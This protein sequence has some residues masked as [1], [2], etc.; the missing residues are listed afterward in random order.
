MYLQ[1]II[2]LPPNNNYKYIVS[3]PPNHYVLTRNN[4]VASQ[5][6]LL[7]VFNFAASSVYFSSIISLPPSCL[8][9]AEIELTRMTP[10]WLPDLF[11]TKK[12][13]TQERS[14]VTFL[15]R[16]RKSPQSDV[17]PSF[18]LKI[19]FCHIF[20]HIA[21]NSGP[22]RLFIAKWNTT[23]NLYFFYFYDLHVYVEQFH[24]KN[25]ADSALP[26]PPRRPGQN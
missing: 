16:C 1:E 25:R 5:S 17:A 7:Q 23:F 26:N 10:D 14:S 22:I 24:V 4:F 18:R 15:K 19:T 20:H 8:W 6:F 9:L 13:N 3:L 11:H 12:T 2:S 21:G